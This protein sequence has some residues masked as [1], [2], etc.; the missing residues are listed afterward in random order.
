M[1]DAA[2]STAIADQHTSE[3]DDRFLVRNPR[4]V[5]ELLQAMIS[6]RSLINAHL[7]G[8]DQSFPTAILEIDED[9]GWLLLDGSPVESANR[10]AEEAS[11]LLCFGQLDKVLVRFRLEGLARVTE[12]RHVAFRAALPED[13]CYLQR[14]EL[15]RLETPIADSPQLLVYDPDGRQQDLRVV[16]ISGGGLAVTVPVGSP[17][18]SLQKRYADCTLLLP[19]HAPLRISLVAC[20]E[21]VMKMP[22]GV[23]LQRVGLRFDGLPRGGDS[24]IQ[25][26]IFR[27]ERQRSARRNGEL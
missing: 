26:Y 27:I 12:D 19:D 22:N 21:R 7:A 1:S 13:I 8:R 24:A 10:A 5:R 3:A 11:H 14:R 2:A 15:Y 6:Q 4:R 25:R 18:F 23:E 9:D 20:N 16:D 17:M